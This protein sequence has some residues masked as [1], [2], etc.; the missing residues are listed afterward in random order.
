MNVNSIHNKTFNDRLPPTFLSQVRDLANWHEYNAFSDP[1][2]GGIGNIAM[3]TM[4]PS[5]IT[6]LQR[7][8]NSSDGLAF[9]VE[10]ISYKPFLSLFNMTNI[11]AQNSSLA[12]IVNYAASVSLEVRQP[13]AGGEPMLRFLFKN[14]TDDPDYVQ[15]G[16]L[17]STGDV[18]LSTF[19]DALNPVA[20][21]T[22]AQWCSACSN[23]AS[24]GCGALSLAASQARPHQP[25]SPIGAGFL[26]AG[27]TIAVFLLMLGALA[28]LGLLTLGRRH[29]RS[30]KSDSVSCVPFP[31]G[32]DADVPKG[33]RRKTYMSGS[34]RL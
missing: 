22:T 10:A 16:L 17:N 14:G 29:R 21:N 19:I 24:R 31:Y 7:I 5:V 4:L 8:S 9:L 13:A 12:G 28:C 15:H 3:R 25:I 26:G 18:A 1:S 27:L 6:G 34:L 30:T 20:I 32:V 11:A 2:L 33:E 23:Q